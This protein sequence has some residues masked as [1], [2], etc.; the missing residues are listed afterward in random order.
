MTTEQQKQPRE[1][2]VRVK[3]REDF[4]NPHEPLYSTALMCADEYFTD[5]KWQPAFEDGGR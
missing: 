5:G 4:T 1:G 3:D 2:A